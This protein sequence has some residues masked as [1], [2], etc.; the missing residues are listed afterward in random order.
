MLDEDGL[1]IKELHELLQES[2]AE[3]A[4]LR[5]LVRDMWRDRD[6]LSYGAAIPTLE[7]MR[8]LGVDDGTR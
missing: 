3:N 7:R 8:E 5:E 2:R 4:K 1:Y 6:A